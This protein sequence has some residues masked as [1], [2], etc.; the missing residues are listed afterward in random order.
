MGM[1]GTGILQTWEKLTENDAQNTFK[2]FVRL[3]YE[4]G[5][6]MDLLFVE[7]IIVSID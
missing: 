3:L 4:C 5:L 6:A 7:T 1:L 2:L